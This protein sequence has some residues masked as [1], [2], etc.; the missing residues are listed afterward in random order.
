MDTY[1]SLL[2]KISALQKKASSLLDNEKKRAVAEMSK[3]IELYDVQPA[4]LFPGVKL[5]VASKSS[6]VDAP[7]SDKRAKRN[8]SPK[9]RDPATKKTWSGYGKKP[10]WLVGNRD[11]YLIEKQVEAGKAAAKPKKKA[12]LSESRKSSVDK[13]IADAT[14]TKP[15]V[16]PLRRTIKRQTLEKGDSPSETGN[17]TPVTPPTA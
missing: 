4:E 13:V 14:K 17:S 9:Y 7:A 8:M 12:S 10:F 15:V 2:G 11:D 1:Q 16:K 3:L 5:S 6:A